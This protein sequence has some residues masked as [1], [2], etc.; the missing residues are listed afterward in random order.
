MIR[1]LRVIHRQTFSVLAIVL[2]LI[3]I[4]S[5]VLRE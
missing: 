3:V 1:P 5:L 2:S 4:L